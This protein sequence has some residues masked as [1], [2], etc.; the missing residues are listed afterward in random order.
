MSWLTVNYGL[1]R[2]IKSSKILSFNEQ[3]VSRQFP[4]ASVRPLFSS[5]LIVDWCD[6]FGSPKFYYLYLGFYRS[7]I[8]MLLLRLS[9]TLL[10]VTSVIA[11]YG[12]KS[13]VISANDK[14]FKEEVLKANGIVIVEFFAPW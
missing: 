8:T 1:V 12:P 10:F 11:L 7:F 2:P 9:I 3:E 4:V 6:L 5:L 13:D 14:N